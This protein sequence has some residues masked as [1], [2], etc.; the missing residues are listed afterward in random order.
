[1]ICN[2][3]TV[4]LS[5]RGRAIER[6]TREREID[7]KRQIL[8]GNLRVGDRD[9]VCKRVGTLLARLSGG[10][11]ERERENKRGRESQRERE[12]EREREL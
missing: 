5:E 7:R 2:V 12:R 4:R 6:E 9:L 1:M 10:L 11:R 8:D 3:C